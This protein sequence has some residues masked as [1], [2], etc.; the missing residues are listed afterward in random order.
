MKTLKLPKSKLDYF[1]SVLQ[2]FGEL[3]APVE[4]NGKYVF[5]RL[6]RWSDVRLDYDRTVIPPKKYVLPPREEMFRFDSRGYTP[7]TDGL[8]H[9][10]V[11]FGVHACDIYGINIMDE[12]FGGKYPDPFYETRRRNLAVIGI[13]CTPDEHCF[14]RS[15]RADFVDHG[16]DLFLHDIGDDYLV[17]IGTAL[18]DDMV[19][20]TAPLF[21]EITREDV[22]EYKRRSAKKQEAFMLDVEI[23]D[24]PEIFEMEYGS[25]IWQEL[26]DRCLGCGACSMVCPTCY[27]YDVTDEVELGSADGVRTRTWDSCLFH[28]HALVAGGENFRESRASRIKFRFYHKQ[29]GFVA[30]YGRPS[31]VG[32]GRCITACPTY[33]HIA[34]VISRLRGASDVAIS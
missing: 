28:T 33:I 13:D 16:F 1:A 4:R 34:E 17:L 5:Q 22:A 3:H 7:V 27:C 2:A 24:L 31:C 25:D 26:G 23:R 9:R 18:G 32:C 11:L 21:T 10:I 19:L 30:E 8:D 20:A 14:C 6:E 15:M 29:R 12:V